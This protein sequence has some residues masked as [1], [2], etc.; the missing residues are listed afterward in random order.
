MN[1]GRVAACARLAA[2]AARYP[3][4]SLEPLETEGV[5]DRDAALAHAVYD[6]GVRRWIT[7]RGLCRGFLRQRWEDLE[8]PVVGALIAGAAQVLFFDRIPVH[9]AIDET[10]EW[11]KSAAPRA[12]GLVNA[13]L[14]RVALSVAREGSGSAS[15]R[16]RWTNA[17]DELPLPD[18]RALRLADPLLPEAELARAA[19][20]TGL[21]LWQVTHWA[22]HLGSEAAVRNSWHATAGAPTVLNVE[23]AAQPP[24]GPHVAP[25]DSPTHRVFTGS[26][27]DLLALLA[28]HP[29][30][31]V[32]DATAAAAL[33]LVGAPPA[34]IVVDLCAGRGTKTRQLLARCPAA[35]VVACEVTPP[36][37]RD[38]EALR[39]AADGRLSVCRP[40][41]QSGE[42]RG[43]CSLVLA[44]VPCS[45]SGVLARRV[46]ARHRCSPRQL[47]RLNG[48]QR[49]IVTL[50][51]SLLAPGGR[52][53]YSTCSLEPEENGHLI[54]WA[55]AEFGMTL[56]V[57]HL[58]EPAGGPGLPPASY[59]DGGYAALLARPASEARGVGGIH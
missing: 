13:V 3:E 10:V 15:A 40:D 20:A 48:Q 49:E 14:R 11:T 9:A 51:V 50:A 35:R 23:A 6:A 28:A 22:E 56:M 25:H 44:D 27:R 59:R 45:N 39:D 31:W 26:R 33:G 8:P 2:E 24:A 58:I 38:L 30:V 53:L 32:Q 34:G 54:A 1:P 52:L 46:E 19:A 42:L 36:R 5:P 17:R 57:D 21:P 16:E 41:E 18:G 29:H 37:L 4:F 12:A 43:R 47:A 7:I 55:C